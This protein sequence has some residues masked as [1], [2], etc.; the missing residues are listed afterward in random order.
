MIVKLIWNLEHIQIKIENKMRTLRSEGTALSSRKLLMYPLW[1]Y[2]KLV[3]F[4]Y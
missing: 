3:V 4:P 1:G 2:N